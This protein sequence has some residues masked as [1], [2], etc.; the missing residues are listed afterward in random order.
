MAVRTDVLPDRYVDPRVIGRGGMG[1]IYLAEDKELARKVVVKVLDERYADRDDLR[2]RFRREALTAARLS[3]EPHT[4]TIFDVGDFGGRPFIV[5]EYLSGGSLA[6]RARSGP[7]SHE[8]AL[9]WLGQAGEAIDAAHARGV[10]HRDIKPANL[11]FNE[12]G[13][14]EVAD[15]GIARAIDDTT[16]MT[17]AGTVMGTAGYLAP[18]QARGEPATPASDRYGLGVVGYE[19]LTGG[20]PFERGSETAEAAAHMN[21]P[22]P[23]ASKRG[24][25][26]PAAVDPVFDRAL[27]KDPGARFGACA[28]FVAALRTALQGEETAPTRAFQPLAAAVPELAYR[29]EHAGTRP[30]WLLPLLVLAFLLALGGGVTAAVLATGTDSPKETPK[31][32]HP[33]TVT[34]RQTETLPGTTVVSTVVT[35]AAAPTTSPT[36]QPAAPAAV[37]VSEAVALTDQA[38]GYLRS[39]DWPSAW[40][41]VKRALP[42]LAGTYRDDFRYEAYS[43][44]DGGKALAELGRCQKAVPLLERSEALQGSRSEIESAKAL[45]GA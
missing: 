14:L 17:Q 24:V 5:M 8:Q 40:K 45:C 2:R 27:A 3:G 43:A 21:E 33:V 19:L 23:P 26:L 15:F 30:V 7:V 25:G 10:V 35:T 11:L 41:T 1:E 32:Q 12:R 22:V 18:E 42:A 34:Q 4:V 20:R 44:Y 28:D 36:P 9:E 38:T 37:S 39:G 6:D 29:S 16:G 31:R 13:D